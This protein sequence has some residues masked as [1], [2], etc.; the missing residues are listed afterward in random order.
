MDQRIAGI[1]YGQNRRNCQ[2]VPKL[3]I[4]QQIPLTLIRTDLSMQKCRD[5]PNSSKLILTF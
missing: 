5:F 4:S 3:K 1:N 2:R